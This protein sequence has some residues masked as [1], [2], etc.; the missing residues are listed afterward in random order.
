MPSASTKVFEVLD[1]REKFMQTPIVS[2]EDISRFHEDG[3]LIIEDFLD[4]KILQKAVSRFE[5][6]FSGEFE[7][8]VAPDKVKW[9]KGRDPEHLSRSMCNIWKADRFLAN[10]ILTE[11][12]GLVASRLMAW[13]GARCNQDSIIW[14]PPGAGTTGFHQDNSYQDWHKPVGIVTCWIPLEKTTP[15]GGTIEYAKGSNKWPLNPR[16]AQFSAPEDYRAELDMAAQAAGRKVEIIPI[17]LSIGGVVFHHGAVWHGANYN[18]SSGSRY[19]LATH[20]MSSE[21]V[22][23][24]TIPSPV[25]NHYKKFND[26]YMDENFFPITWAEDGKRSPFIADYVK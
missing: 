9:L 15:D 8:G 16:V 2:E 18:R 26:L 14:V 6:V 3:F 17:E 23:H 24:P 1:E 11:K 13:P 5:F 21:S 4:E 10:I 25:F 22:F 7:T 12:I 20:C 19:T